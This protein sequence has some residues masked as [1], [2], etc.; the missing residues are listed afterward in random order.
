MCWSCKK[1]NLKKLVAEKDIPVFKIG[2][3]ISNGIATS[4]FFP[5]SLFY[6]ENET[7]VENYSPLPTWSS[8]FKSYVI[9]TAIHS[10]AVSKLRLKET[11]MLFD[12]K[13]HPM[14]ETTSYGIG[15]DVIVRGQEF[16]IKNVAV[17]LCVIPKGAE[18]YINTIGEIASNKLKVK[19]II[20][21]PFVANKDNTTSIRSVDRVNKILNDWEHMKYEG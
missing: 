18:Y 14:V 19:K 1:D 2:R 21:N 3:I 12:E 4:Y 10:Y 16:Y 20:E 7:Y 6:K 17:M 13:K 9:N 5:N 8:I 11:Y 15:P